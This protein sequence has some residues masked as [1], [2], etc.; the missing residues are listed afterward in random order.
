[1]IKLAIRL[2][3]ALAL[4]GWAWHYQLGDDSLGRHLTKIAQTKPAETLAESAASEAHTLYAKVKE[5][6]KRQRDSEVTEGR[7]P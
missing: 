3:V 5:A 2:A 4:A 7:Q 6:V 1:M